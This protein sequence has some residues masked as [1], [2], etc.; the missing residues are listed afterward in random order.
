MNPNENL[1]ANLRSLIGTLTLENLAMQV[2][3]EAQRDMIKDLEV[4]L[5]TPKKVAEPVAPSVNEVA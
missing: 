2:Q 4:A 3:V 5:L 1:Q